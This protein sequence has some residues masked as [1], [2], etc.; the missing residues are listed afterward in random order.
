MSET[1][2]N[3]AMK[4]RSKLLRLGLLALAIAI[5]GFLWLMWRADAPYRERSDLEARIASLEESIRQQRAEAIRARAECQADATEF[6]GDK[7]IQSACAQELQMTREIDAQLIRAWS[8]QR[9][10]AIDRLDVVN[11]EIRALQARSGVGK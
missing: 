2:D 8:E 5:A 4:I 1:G 11:S 3:G 7:A 6:P 10:K 9:A